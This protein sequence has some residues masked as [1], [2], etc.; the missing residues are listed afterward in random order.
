MKY[1]LIIVAYLLTNISITKVYAMGEF[2]FS[3]YM[4]MMATYTKTEKKNTTANKTNYTAYDDAFASDKVDFDTRNNIIGLQIASKVT[5][6]LDVTL[7]LQA[8]GGSNKYNISADWVYASY[9]LADD[10]TVRVGR[11]KGPFFMVSEYSTV[12]Y[13][14]PWATV[15]HEV[16]STNPIT[17][18]S[19]LDFVYN[20]N[21]GD[22]DFLFELYAGSG[23]KTI[24]VPPSFIGSDANTCADK[25]VC[26]NLASGFAVNFQT[27]NMVGFNS[28]IGTKNFTFRAGYFTADVDV[29]G[30]FLDQTSDFGG[31]GFIVDWNDILIYSE[32][33]IRDT[34]DRLSRTFPD[35]KAWYTTLGYRIGDFTPYVTLSELDK[36]KN[37]SIY[38]VKQSS[39]T[40]GFRLEIGTTDAVK[41]EVHQ[42][43]PDSDAG[44][45][46]AYGL[47][48][49]PVKDNEGTVYTVSYN[50]IF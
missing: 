5:D 34:S 38:A 49:D 11:F 40:V 17:A 13:A 48:N 31:V 35:Q 23:N 10:F 18:V 39:V 47:F 9:A 50:L 45:I 3:G 27:S 2:E 36:G 12:G 44:D 42:A 7:I 43:E 29:P 30:F 1:W 26:P 22:W 33:V 37:K 24:T 20:N 6:E 4:T 46:G 41:F 16:Y 25:T 28:S 21:F 8:Q 15:P 19:G 32:Y 14:Y